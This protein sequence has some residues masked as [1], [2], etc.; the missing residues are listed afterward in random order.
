MTEQE[1][2][3]SLIA[4]TTTNFVE[5]TAPGIAQYAFY[6]Y[7]T[8]ASATLAATTINS[9]AFQNCTNLEVVDLTNT[10]PATINT[11]A[12]ASCSKLAHLILRSTTMATL[13]S[14]AAFTGTKIAS[15]NGAIYVPSE[16]VDTYK[17]NANWSNYFIAPISSY[18]M[19]D[20]S[21][22]TDDWATIAAGTNYANYSIGD[23]KLID[24]NGTQIY[25]QLVA[26]DTD[27]LSSDHTSTA[28]M[29]WIA[30]SILTT[31]NMNSTNTTEN[32]W[33]DTSMRSWL[34]DTILP[35]LPSV[36][37]SNIKTVDKTYRS[38][39]PNDETLTAEDTIWIP[40]YKEV[41][42]TNSSYIESDG[43]TYSGIFNSNANRIKY[44]SSGSADLWWLRSA[45]STTSFSFVYLNG[46]EYYLNASSAYGVV[47]GFCI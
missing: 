18:P 31:H 7:T 13:S 30:K 40:S 38:K 29:T 16:L 27:V 47:F 46:N 8:L 34:R 11:S 39:S 2:F 20:L 45:Y 14:T 19:T 33:V 10:S 35:T 3:D 41:G 6:N 42:Y 37:Q 1:N 36:V 25:M 12:F 17:A 43:V 9:N 21:T 4:R 28:N 15:G 32:G 22:I 26:K 24:V 23:T 44:N 5:D